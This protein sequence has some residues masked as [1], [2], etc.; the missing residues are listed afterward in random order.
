MRPPTMGLEHRPHTF[1]FEFGVYPPSPPTR[2]GVLSTSEVRGG[3][4]V[5]VALNVCQAEWRLP[6][7]GVA[8]VASG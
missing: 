4:G 5:R 2:L 1:S 8:S 3:I 6:I 7:S